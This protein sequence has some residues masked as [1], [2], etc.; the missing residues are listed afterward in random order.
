MTAYTQEGLAK[1]YDFFVQ[2]PH[3]R[4]PLA[5]I[6]FVKSTIDFGTTQQVQFI[7]KGSVAVPGCP[8][9]IAHI[10]RA[11]C[12]MPLHEIALPAIQLAREGVRIS[13]YQAYTMRILEPILLHSVEMREVFESKG[14]LIGEGH[15]LQQA[16]LADTLEYLSREGFEAF[17]QGEL[18][19]M[20]VKD[21]EE[22]GGLIQQQ[23]LESY[24]VLER[25]PLIF[26]YN[27]HQIITNPPPSMGGSMI[28]YGL[29]SRKN[30]KPSLPKGVPYIH[31]LIDLI[32]GMDR[33]REQHLNPG[34]QAGHWSTEKL[35]QMLSTS[36]QE[37]K[38][39]LGNTTHFSIIDRQGN[40]AS[41]TTT[42]GGVSGHKI[43]GT[44]IS[45]NNMLGEL[46][47][48]P[49]GYE[50]WP[51]NQRVSSMMSPTIVLAQ[52]QAHIVL[53]TG[54]SSRIRTAILQV[55][56]NLITHKMP[57]EKAVNYPRLHIEDDHLNIE[58]GLIKPKYAAQLKVGKLTLWEQKSMFFGGVHT[59]MRDVNGKLSATA[60]PRR[61]GAVSEF[62]SH[63]FPL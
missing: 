46:D 19:D 49:L 37:R 57:L 7:G 27:G 20:F 1:V 6:D 39:L 63:T 17:Y 55:L 4:R 32:V 23:D 13:A 12:K 26:P 59:V 9:G 52:N 3:K 29:A 43:P 40:A 61:D 31:E 58:P 38:D 42:M 41:V 45:T 24:Q 22:N 56:I 16:K 11:L 15:L 10:H 53:G 8:A 28:S 47:L 34:I 54:G 50:S 35:E 30:V 62:G 5:E 51:L 21:N 2:T 18:A 14:K 33:F 48:N 44:G 25:K 36:R 60:D